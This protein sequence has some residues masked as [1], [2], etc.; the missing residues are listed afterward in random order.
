[1]EMISY[2][3]LPGQQQHVH[4]RLLIHDLLFPFVDYVQV[5][6]KDKSI[7]ILE[8]LCSINENYQ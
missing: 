6:Y 7:R 1:M 5:T 3:L 8:E 4:V 2:Y